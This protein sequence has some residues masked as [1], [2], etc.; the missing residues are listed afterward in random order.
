MFC[1][2]DFSIPIVNWTFYLS[3]FQ[4][5][6]SSVHTVTLTRRKESKEH[7]LVV[8]VVVF[9]SGSSFKSKVDLRDRVYLD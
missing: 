7:R 9:S 4:A 5:V 8:V 6:I 2:L 1:S 3:F